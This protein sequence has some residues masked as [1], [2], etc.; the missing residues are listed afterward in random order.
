[1]KKI[2]TIGLSVL[3]SVGLSVY[4][5]MQYDYGAT[6]VHAMMK[7]P[8]GPKNLKVKTI[9][10]DPGHGGID[11]GSLGSQGTLE[12]KMT[13]QTA[14]AIQQELQRRTKAQV[15]LTREQDD[16]VSLQERVAIAER[17][18]ADLYV[19]IHYDAFDTAEAEGMTTYYYQDN[20]QKLANTIHANLEQQNMEM[21]DRGVQFG[22]YYVLRRNPRPSVLLE[23]GYIS[24]PNDE[25]RMKSQ[26]F[27]KQAAEAVVNGIIDYLET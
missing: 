24:N 6:E 23:L 13:L 16:T 21:R 3:L 19:S 5:Y 26:D 22:D 10:I 14:K 1:M 25:Q 2:A 4:V 20:N 9:V 18:S 12:K 11:S 8:E 17:K 15:V 27:Q 7:A